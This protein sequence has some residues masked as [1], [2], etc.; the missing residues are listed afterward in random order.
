[1][2]RYILNVIVI[3]TFHGV[4]WSLHLPVSSHGVLFLLPYS[5]VNV[6][7][8]HTLFSVL[9]MEQRT[10]FILDKFSTTEPHPQPSFHIYS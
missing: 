10:L 5:S 1:M 2:Q 3:E 9:G 4:L 7:F 6:L 8:F